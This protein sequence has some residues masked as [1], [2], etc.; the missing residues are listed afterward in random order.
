MYVEKRE[1][2]V[3]WLKEEK[4]ERE[5]KKEISGIKRKKMEVRKEGSG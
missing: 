4:S 1:L 3:E 5:I 2:H